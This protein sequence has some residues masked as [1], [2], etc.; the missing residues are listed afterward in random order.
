[1]LGSSRPTVTIAAAILKKEKLIEYT[2]GTIRI[3]D[4]K[5]LERRSCEC[6]RVIKDHLDN[7]ADFETGI[8]V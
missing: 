6:Y 5:G 1:M 4:P 8:T 3:V 7:Y 2:R